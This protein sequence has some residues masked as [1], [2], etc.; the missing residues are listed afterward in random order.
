MNLN[1]MW[2]FAAIVVVL[3]VLKRPA[4]STNYLDTLYNR[5]LSDDPQ[6]GYLKHGESFEYLKEVRSLGP[7]DTT[8]LLV[9]SHS[10]DDNNGVGCDITNIDILVKQLLHSKDED[11][12]KKQQ[13]WSQRVSKC[14]Y[15]WRTNLKTEVLTLNC[16]E[17]W[18]IQSMTEEIMKVVAVGDSTNHQMTLLSRIETSEFASAL[19]PYLVPY[20][21]AHTHAKIDQFLDGRVKHGEIF[22]RECTK[23]LTDLCSSVKAKLGKSVKLFDL[24]IYESRVVYRE[25]DEYIRDWLNRIEVCKIVHS[26]GESISKEA[27]KLLR[28]KCPSSNDEGCLPVISVIM[29]RVKVALQGCL[30][31]RV[32]QM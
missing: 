4:A 21:E 23:L 26:R 32:H 9:S 13:E 29:K 10:N 25:D 11:R 27:Y 18:L 15:D 16:E 30:P 17:K 19:V 7:E 6:Y 20:F 8:R 2:S 28:E 12:D 5:I 22:Q 31:K 24:F 3:S 1:K 14:K